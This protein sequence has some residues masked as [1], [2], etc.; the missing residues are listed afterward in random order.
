MK[1]VLFMAS[2]LLFLSAC[3][4]DE[5]GGDVSSP[6]MEDIKFAYYVEDSIP[7]NFTYFMDA[8]AALEVKAK[9]FEEKMY[10]LQEEG[11]QLVNTLQRQQGAG[12]LS[13][14]QIAGYQNRIGVIQ[15]QIQ[16]LQET[17]GAQLER[18]SMDGTV[19]MFDKMEKYAKNYA[20]EHGITIFLAHKAA[21]Q[22]IYIDPSMD[23]TMDFIDY[24][25]NQELGGNSEE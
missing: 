4:D 1:K 19:E 18:E 22:I 15:N 17:E 7:N 25:N 10:K 6:S 12:L 9:A 5:K 20:S 14:N 8:Q 2:A 11:Q 24:M 23:V 13:D 16:V 21:G 3:G